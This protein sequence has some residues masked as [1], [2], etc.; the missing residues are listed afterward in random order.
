M[1]AQGDDKLSYGAVDFLQ[2]LA[3]R[4]LIGAIRLL[5][6]RLRAPLCGFVTARLIAPF[7]GYDRRIRANLALVWPGLTEADIR[8]LVTRVSHNAGATLIEVY[9]G[10][11][12]RKAVAPSPVL[13]EGVASLIAAKER[14]QGVLL[15]SGHFGN[16]DVARAVLSSLGH[17]VGALYRPFRNGY[18]DAHYRATIS[19]IGTPIFPRG[20]RGLAEMVK[21]LRAGGMVGMLIDQYMTRSPQLDFM[22]RPAR[23]AT[24]AADL[25]LKYGLLLVPVYGRRN[26]ASPTGFELIVEPPVPHSDPLTMTQ[27]LNASL[28]AQVRAHPEQWL[29]IHNRWKA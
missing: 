1:A 2:N 3:L 25:A 24:S 16:Y 17:P 9:S 29:W 6:F 19:A 11:A 27:A 14:G 28:E 8:R 15:I 18:F 5:P 20:R 10:A 4:A 13:G 12:F 7:A 23:T 22:G 26:P 21:F